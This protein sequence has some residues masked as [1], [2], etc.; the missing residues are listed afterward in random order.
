[1]NK[2]R[3]WLRRHRLWIGFLAVIIPLAIILGLQYQSLVK[4]EKISPIAHKVMLK[5]YLYRVAKEVEGFYRAGAERVLN[6]SPY[7]CTEDRIQKVSYH[8][9]KKSISGAHEL[10]VALFSK[11]DEPQIFFYDPVRHTMKPQPECPATRAI[12]AACA[13]LQLVNLQGV[14]LES[15]SL[16][17]NERDPQHRLILNPILDES[18]QVIGVAGMI[19]DVAYFRDHFLPQVIQETLSKSFPD[20]DHDNIIVTVRDGAGQLVYA[21]QPVQG[22][23]DIVRLPLPFIFKDWRLGIRSRYQTPEQWAKRYFALNLSLSIL[24][25][26]VLIGGIVLAWRTAS[27]EMKLSQMKTDFVSNVSHELRTPLA[28]IRVFGE[29]LRLG[30]V[31]E[32]DKIRQYG[33]Y[34]EAESQ[35][36]TQLVNNILDFS[37]IESGQKTY[38]FEPA[39]I[40]EIVAETL[41]AFE[42]QLKEKGFIIT[43]E[44]PETPLP[45]III[46]AQALA[47]AVMNLLDNAVKYSGAAREITVRLALADE[48]ITL[49]VTDRGIGIPAEEQEKI[50]ERFHRVST[51]LV[52]D[53]KGSGLGLSIV[54]HIVEAHGGRVT[55]NSEVGKGS[56][57]TLHLPLDRVG[58]RT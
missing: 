52:H 13:P 10:F 25:A 19:V 47:Q 42:V 8:F 7:T 33:Q 20:G 29:F 22:Q 49:S 28:S 2:F 44:A 32:P 54:K 31:K 48:H 4:L 56:T 24:M 55:V 6:V 27:R 1:M 50:F 17:V 11:K 39:D 35:R 23:D 12:T 15:A 40:E 45:P 37:K 16:M 46:D 18:S 51:G 30:R 36:L 53:V 26:L 3:A 58:Y 41:K 34:I 14:R 43:F 57:F 21:T 5:G 38:Q 9:E